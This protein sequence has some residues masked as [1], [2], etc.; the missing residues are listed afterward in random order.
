M[1]GYVAGVL[2]TFFESPRFPG[3]LDHAQ[4]SLAMEPELRWG[5]ANGRHELSI[6]PFVRLDASDEDRSHADLREAFWRGVFGDWEVLVGSNVVFWGVTESRHLVNIVNQTDVR[7]D[8]DEE[9]KLGQPMI[10]IEWQRPWGR[11]SGMAL[12]GFRDQPFP[13]SEGRLR[14]PLPVNRNAAVFPDGKRAVDFALRYAHFIGDFD[15]GVHA[16]HGTGR[17]PAFLANDA[18][19][20]LK[21]LY[22]TITQVGLDL[23]YT[24][25]AWLWKL[26]AI[27]RGGEGRTFGATVGGVEYTRYQVFDSAADLGLLGEYLYDG[28]DDTAPQ[29]VFDNHGFLGARWAL[30]DTQD[31][32][33]LA[34]AVVDLGDGTTATRIEF[35][36]RLTD[37]LKLEI[38][39]RLFG[40]VD[41]ENILQSLSNDSFLT[42][43]LS[44]FF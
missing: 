40:S 44:V 6:T 26:E 21:P 19:T 14:L 42:T 38:E 23:Q 35:E 5:T 33:V 12:L 39:S 20:Q 2:R 3:Q 37:R 29:T 13:G 10:S 1:S 17:E 7:E 4:P 18:G 32:A 27:G 41:Q 22:R 25:D 34:G 11:V 24:R 28:R 30:N 31:T 16:F 36:R 9:D 43:R 15:V 8:V